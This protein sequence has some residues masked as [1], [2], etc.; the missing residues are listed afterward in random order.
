MTGKSANLFADDHLLAEKAAHDVVVLEGDIPGF[1][2]LTLAEHT[3]IFEENDHADA[4]YLIVR[5]KVEIRKGML[6]KNPQS[7]AKLSHGDIFGELAMFDDSPRAAQAIAR[8]DVEVIRISREEFLNRLDTTDV[9]MKAIVLYVVKCM[10]LATN[11]R[12]HRHEPEW[13]T[14]DDNA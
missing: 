11:D 7:V 6:S 4:A 5:G 8:S 9:V 2:R 13:A 3:V 12:M 10:R 1:D 14:W